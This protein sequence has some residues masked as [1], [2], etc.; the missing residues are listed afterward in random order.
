MAPLIQDY[1]VM[2]LASTSCVHHDYSDFLHKMATAPLH[3]YQQPQKITTC[4]HRRT[5]SFA[6]VS[7]THE[8][9]HHND[10]TPEEL[11]ASWYD[12]NGMRQ[13]KQLAKAEAKFWDSG[14]LPNNNEEMTIRG[15]EGR[16]YEGARKKT[17]QRRDVYASVFSE[18]AFQEEV[19]YLDEEMIADAYFLYSESCAMTAQMMGHRDEM[20]ARRIRENQTTRVESFGPGFCRT[21]FVE[22]LL[23]STSSN[24]MVLSTE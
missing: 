16:L 6:A 4:S 17:Q 21:T 23:D 7:T 5:V 1:D 18:I 2:S 24:A 3:E 22:N 9:L 20:E 15:L 11:E 19:D 13:I 12:R 14:A 10:Y 8:V